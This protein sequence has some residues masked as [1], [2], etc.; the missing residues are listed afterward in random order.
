MNRP[1]D[2]AGASRLYLLLVLPMLVALNLV[3]VPFH[4]PDDYDHVKR[5][6]SVAH[7]GLWPVN[8]AGRMSGGYVD[9]SL[10]DMIEAQKPAVF[11]WPRQ[12][13]LQLGQSPSDAPP[14]VRNRPWSGQQIYSEFPGASSY[15]P[16]VYLPQAAALRM[17]EAFSL[18]VEHSVLAARLVNGAAA[19]GLTAAALATLPFGTGV[20]LLVLLLPKTLLQ[21]ASNS[22]DPMLH[23]LTL[24]ILAFAG[25]ALMQRRTLR[26]RHFLLIASALLVLSGA[27]PPMAALALL[28]L[29]L[30][31]RQRSI[32][33]A[34]ILIVPVLG[35]AAWFGLVMPMIVDTRCGPTGSLG[36]KVVDFLVRGP[37][38]VA[39]SIWWYKKYYLASFIGELGWGSGPRSEVNSLPFAVYVAAAAAAPIALIRDMSAPAGPPRSWRIVLLAAAAA[40]VAGIFLVMHMGC[41]PPARPTIVGVQGRYFVPS[42]LLGAA[43]VSGVL[44]PIGVVRRAFVP[45][46]VLFALF[47]FGVLVSEGLR[48][49]WTN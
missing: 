28:P 33:A 43:A 2:A 6:Y 18:S 44:R 37:V 38:L 36:D 16:L 17:G 9:S 30:A 21:F 5:A 1:V 35:A 24:A 32:L 34:A 10:V 14:K 3:F 20:A 42:V 49:Y 45:A 8:E 48:I 7:G 11:G 19:V 15:L 25:R 47:G 4:A 27:R 12:G 23:A 31:W 39:R 29:W 22:A 46:L 26:I 13:Q 41:T 40:I